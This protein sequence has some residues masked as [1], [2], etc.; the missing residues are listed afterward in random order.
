MFF[1]QFKAKH[2][3]TKI[4]IC[5]DV[6][7]SV[8]RWQLFQIPCRVESGGLF[9]KWVCSIFV[10]PIGHPELGD[11]TTEE[12]K[13]DVTISLVPQSTPAM[14]EDSAATT[15]QQEHEKSVYEFAVLLIR[16][17]IEDKFQAE[18]EKAF[19]VAILLRAKQHICDSKQPLWFVLPVLKW[20][21]FLQIWRQFGLVLELGSSSFSPSLLHWLL[22]L[23]FSVWRG[24]FL[25]RKLCL[26]QPFITL[27]KS[28]DFAW[29]FFP[30]VEFDCHMLAEI[31]MVYASPQLLLLFC[32]YR[33][34]QRYTATT[35][36][37]QAPAEENEGNEYLDMATYTSLNTTDPNTRASK[38]SSSTVY[39]DTCTLDYAEPYADGCGEISVNYELPGAIGAGSVTEYQTEGE[40]PGDYKLPGAIGA[41]DVTFYQIPEQ[42]DNWLGNWGLWFSV[43]PLI[44]WELL[45]L[46]LV[47]NLLVKN[48]LNKMYLVQVNSWQLFLGY[49]LRENVQ[50]GGGSMKKLFWGLTCC[51][52]FLLIMLW[53]S[54]WQTVRWCPKVCF[55]NDKCM[56]AYSD[57]LL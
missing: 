53:E 16:S 45:L 25:D 56:V 6:G 1:S 51:A 33:K 35:S 23:W 38:M 29:M 31:S 2:S 48:Q 4:H 52:C 54:T 21:G 20:C 12:P 10:L 44:C 55:G 41:G 5:Q 43:F 18:E 49:V 57:S 42:R 17:H 3:V 14:D 11:L 8:P 40:I 36:E 24:N 19:S 26:V 34:Q 50:T 46:F 22:W 39:E 28:S 13:P 37:A 7:P 15:M 47:M 9:W 32:F 30:S 27:A